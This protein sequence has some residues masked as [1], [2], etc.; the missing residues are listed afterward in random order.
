M[1]SNKIIKNKIDKK[2]IKRKDLNYDNF[3]VIQL[4]FNRV[5]KQIQILIRAILLYINLKTDLSYSHVSY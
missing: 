3:L 5:F 4:F 1:I 2:N